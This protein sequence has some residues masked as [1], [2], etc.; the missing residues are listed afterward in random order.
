MPR[1]TRNVSLIHPVCQP[2]PCPPET[3][4][5]IENIAKAQTGQDERQAPLLVMGSTVLRKVGMLQ[6]ALEFLSNRDELPALKRVG[7]IPRRQS[8][9]GFPRNG[10][11][12]TPVFFAASFGRVRS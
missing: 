2:R 1:T 7:P 6:L 11:L 3:A 10:D 5:G 4:V 12:H 8:A 9:D